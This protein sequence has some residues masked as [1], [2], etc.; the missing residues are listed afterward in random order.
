MDEFQAAVAGWDLEF[1]QLDRGRLGA[2]L[3]QRANS[4]G[5][6]T[7]VE[8]DR[9]VAQRGGPPQGMRTFAVRMDRHPEMRWFGHSVR[10]DSL[11]CFHPTDEFECL[12]PAG[13]SVYTFSLDESRIVEI[14]SDLGHPDLFDAMDRELAVEAGGQVALA[15]LRR[16]LP[17]LLA[18]IEETMDCSTDGRAVDDLADRIAEEL[19]ALLIATERSPHSETPSA[20]ARATRRAVDYLLGHARAPVT[21]TDLCEVA[22]VSSRT[23][24]RAFQKS[25]GVTPKR[26]IDAVR[27]QSVRR[28]LASADPQAQVSDIA[29]AWGYWHLGDFAMNYRREFSELPS[30]TLAREPARRRG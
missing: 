3:S 29:N 26:C 22:G 11:M 4:I 19:V 18:P 23:L 14:A 30:A 12:S 6:F 2:H 24:T 27:L 16:F 17:R 1:R 25:L 20:R 9:P 7:R 13:F 28:A 10:P 8:L 15:R 5:N 21:V